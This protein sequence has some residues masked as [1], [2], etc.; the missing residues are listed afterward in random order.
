[1]C[2]YAENNITKFAVYQIR[3]VL[4]KHNTTLAKIK[5]HG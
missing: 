2:A 3:S 5:I 1:M 4:S